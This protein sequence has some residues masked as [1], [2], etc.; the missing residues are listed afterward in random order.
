MSTSRARA[1][2]QAF[3]ANGSRLQQVLDPTNQ[4]AASF[5]LRDEDATFGNLLKHQLTGMG[6]TF[7]SYKCSAAGNVDR[8]DL[9]LSL[10]TEERLQ[11]PAQ[12]TV[13]AIDALLAEIATMEAQ[14]GRCV[15][16]PVE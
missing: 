7:V 16:V 15:R 9:T 14:V 12:V 8:K 5:I 3:V 11:H 1:E 13:D 4:Y 6:V 10:N 2:K